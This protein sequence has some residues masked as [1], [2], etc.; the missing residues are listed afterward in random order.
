[1]WYKLD[2]RAGVEPEKGVFAWTWRLLL[3][4]AQ[5]ASIV[6]YVK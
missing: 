2:R 5:M 1:M 3:H 4:V 6:R